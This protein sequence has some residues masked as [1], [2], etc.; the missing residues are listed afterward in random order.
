[1]LL[2]KELFHSKKNDMFIISYFICG[3]FYSFYLQNKIIENEQFFKMLQEEFE[4]NRGMSVFF[5]TMFLT[6]LFIWPIV[7][8]NEL[9]NKQDF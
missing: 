3:I 4:D 7:L 9:N 1:M 8:F 2:K 5:L 6:N